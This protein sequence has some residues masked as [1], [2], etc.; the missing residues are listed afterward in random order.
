MVCQ[1]ISCHLRKQGNVPQHMPIDGGVLYF[2]CGYHLEI[3]AMEQHCL[4]IIMPVTTQQD[5]QLDLNGV[6]VC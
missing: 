6:S 1:L 4:F 2:S 5:L 3:D